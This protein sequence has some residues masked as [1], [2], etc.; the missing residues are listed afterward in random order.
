MTIRGKEKEKGV[1]DPATTAHELH[2][3]SYLAS[4]RLFVTPEA[5]RNVTKNEFKWHIALR[6]YLHICKEAAIYRYVKNCGLPNSYSDGPPQA[7]VLCVLSPGKRV[8]AY[9][10]FSRLLYSRQMS[11]PLLIRWN[12]Y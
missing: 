7:G 4:Q 3:C 2:R 5:L 1:I 12:G 6:N 9:L 11:T 8:A 10:G